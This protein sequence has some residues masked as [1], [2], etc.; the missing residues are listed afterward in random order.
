MALIKVIARGREI[1]ITFSL[2][3]LREGKYPSYTPADIV[4]KYT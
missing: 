1:W 2:V 4:L 3:P